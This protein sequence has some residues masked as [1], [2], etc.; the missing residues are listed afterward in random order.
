MRRL[1][2]RP[3]KRRRTIK[4]KCVLPSSASLALRLRS[5]SVLTILGLLAAAFALF[6]LAG[7]AV[8]WGQTKNIANPALLAVM[9]SAHASM[10]TFALNRNA[11]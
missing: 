1:F 7:G 10:I 11:H 2:V 8:A 6:G 3:S 9:L 5:A 4:I